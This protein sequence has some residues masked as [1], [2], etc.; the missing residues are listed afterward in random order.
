M[1]LLRAYWQIKH[2]L[3]LFVPM[4]YSSKLNRKIWIDEDFFNGF[5]LLWRELLFDIDR[6]RIENK[7]IQFSTFWLYGFS[8]LFYDCV[9]ERWRSTREIL[10][11]KNEKQRTK[12]EKN[13]DTVTLKIVNNKKHQ[14]INQREYFSRHR[15]LLTF[16]F[17][18]DRDSIVSL[19]QINGMNDRSLIKI[20]QRWLLFQC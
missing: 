20:Q 5:H 14:S 7:W 6:N 8:H 18:W 10:M 1:D 15:Q 2:F 17:Q 19:H 9:V 3:L 4:E 13:Q 12:K 16:V 11:M